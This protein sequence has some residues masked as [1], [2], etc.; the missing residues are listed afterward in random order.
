MDTDS[1]SVQ[2]QADDF[3]ID[4]VED[5]ETR[6]GTSNYEFERQL[7]RGINKKNIGL[8]KDELSGKLMT[9]FAI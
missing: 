7:P 8:K 5:V 4:I 1:F 2:I 3:Y 9:E 6:F